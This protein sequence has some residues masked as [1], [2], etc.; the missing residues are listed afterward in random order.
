MNSISTI[1]GL[2]ARVFLGG[3]WIY[4]GYDKIDGIE[5]LQ[6]YMGSFGVPKFLAWP[7]V[8]LELIGGIM[9]LLGF[10]SRYAALALALFTVAAAVI[11]HN[12]FANIEQFRY[13]TKNFAI[14][15][16][17]LLLVAN[18]PGRGAINQN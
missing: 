12:E 8:A 7:V 3:F 11:F 17:L 5:G 2:V 10:F 14:A 16:G 4:F 18:G 9:I 13:F 6:G 1:A 15:G